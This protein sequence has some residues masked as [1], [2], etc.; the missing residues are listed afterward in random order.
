MTVIALG[1]MKS[2]RAMGTHRRQEEHSAHALLL[3]SRIPEDPLLR[4]LDK[5][6]DLGGGSPIRDQ[7]QFSSETVL[8]VDTIAL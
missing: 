8:G 4:K 3:G 7:N 6:L 5:G 1:Y 2:G